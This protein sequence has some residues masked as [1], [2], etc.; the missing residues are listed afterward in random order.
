MHTK[1][2]A[3]V[4]RKAGQQQQQQQHMSQQGAAGAADPFAQSPFQA[5]SSAMGDSAAAADAAAG[6]LMDGLLGLSRGGA[7]GFGLRCTAA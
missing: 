5:L 6:S 4:A 1:S 7:G 2:R 3:W